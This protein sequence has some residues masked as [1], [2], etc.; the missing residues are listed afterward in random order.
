[1]G[2][3]AGRA[4]NLM[5]N[6]CQTDAVFSD[7]WPRSNLPADYFDPVVSEKPVL[8][9]PGELDPVTPPRW[10]EAAAKHLDNPLHV[11][12]PGAVHGISS[13]GCVPKSMAQFLD[14]AGFEG[15]DTSCVDVL[16]RPRFL[17]SF[18]IPES[19]TPTS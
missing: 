4:F 13:N 18:S 1:M 3:D 10:R 8:V 7:F 12:V 15:L 19:A 5:L 9:L 14:A 17:R 11:V 2:E 6:D 16:K